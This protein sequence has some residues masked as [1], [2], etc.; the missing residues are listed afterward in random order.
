MIIYVSYQAT[1]NLELKYRSP[2]R[3]D[4]EEDSEESDNDGLDDN[5]P[6]FV[7]PPAANGAGGHSATAATAN[8]LL[9]GDGSGAGGG[10]SSGDDAL[11]N[12]EQNIANLE[13]SIRVGQNHR[14]VRYVLL[15]TN[16]ETKK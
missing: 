4:R 5:G 10:G 14:N 3:D 2:I 6:A 8:S 11:I 16:T 13:R 1:V 15:R 12:L 7:P 9:H